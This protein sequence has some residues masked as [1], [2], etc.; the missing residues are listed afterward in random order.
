LGFTKSFVCSPVNPPFIYGP[1]VPHFPIPPVTSLGS[2]RFVYAL[3][4]GRVP[5]PLP[6]PYCD[7]RDVA[8]AHVAALK[9]SPKLPAQDKRI[10]TSGGLMLWKEATQYLAETQ[11]ELKTRLPTMESFPPDG[12]ASTIDVTRA[13]DLLG[14]ESWV[15]WRKTLDDTIGELLRAEQVWALSS[16]L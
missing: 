14:I 2:N 15:P 8:R 7:V 16:K 9:I 4:N 12:K 1:F 13:K 5:P 11:P 10:L 6:P 3:L